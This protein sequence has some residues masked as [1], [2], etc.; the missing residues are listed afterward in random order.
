MSSKGKNR[1]AA[2]FVLAVMSCAALLLPAAQGEELAAIDVQERFLEKIPAGTEIGKTAPRGWTHLVFIATPKIEEGDVDA[3]P[4]LAKNIASMLQLTVLANAKREGK[5]GPW[6]L[7]KVAVG[8]ATPIGG[9]RII[10]DSASERRLGANLDF[11]ER[12]VLSGQERY[13]AEEKGVTQV[14]TAPNMVVFDA[15]Q[16]TLVKSKHRQMVVRHAVVIDPATGGMGALVWLL[17]P[18]SRGFSLAEEA[19]HLLPSNYHE[20][21]VMHVDGDQV[22]FLGMPGPTALAVV[23][24]PA[25][26]EIPFT[27]EL[28]EVAALSRFTPEAAAEL[29][30]AIWK[31]LSSAG[32]K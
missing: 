12:T 1:L 21:R 23:S 7:D 9:K 14:V 18:S 20:D 32:V 6:R 2:A 5:D 22:N 26:T 3:L 13:L 30:A 27:P 4:S 24:L 15:R 28:R 11:I 8:F 16:V 29:E 31:G 17:E 25:G 10:I 19:M